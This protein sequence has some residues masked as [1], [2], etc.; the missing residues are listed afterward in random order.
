L[1]DVGFVGVEVEAGEALADE[2]V[3]RVVWTIHDVFECVFREAREVFG[4]VVKK[5]FQFF[6]FV[7]E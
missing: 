2:T 7:H 6:I 5:L 3:V 1:E 4:V